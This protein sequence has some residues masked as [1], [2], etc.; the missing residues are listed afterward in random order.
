MLDVQH[1]RESAESKMA[2]SLV[3][4]LGK[5]F[6]GMSLP[7]KLDRQQEA[8]WLEDRKDHFVISW[9]S[10]LGNIVGP[11]LVSQVQT[12]PRLFRFF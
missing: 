3:V 12:Q 8:A 5:A 10:Q 1:Y 6:N 11:T 9:P 7:S 2:S 4:Y